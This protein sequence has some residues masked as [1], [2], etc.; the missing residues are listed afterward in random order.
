MTR[1]KRARGVRAL[2]AALMSAGLIVITGVAAVGPTAQAAASGAESAGRMVLDAADTSASTPCVVSINAPTCQS[3]N[4]RL[5]VDVVNNGDTSA[6]TFTYSIDWGDGSA[7]QQV[8]FDG[9]PQ[10]GEY[11]LAAHTYHATQ[12]HSYSITASPVSVTGNCTSGSGSYTFTLD[13]GG[14]APAAPSNLTVKAIDPHDIKLNW[15]DN[16]NN[17]T[18]FEINNGVVS[19]DVAANSTSYTWGGLAPGTYMCFR[20]RAHNSA[21]N[22]AWD[23][24]VS[25]WYACT[26]TPKPK[27]PVN[28]TWSG[29]GGSASVT[30]VGATHW[31]VP[32]LS[33]FGQGFTQPHPAAAQWIGLGGTGGNKDLE[34]VGILSQCVAGVQV[35]TLVWEI[36]PQ[37][38]QPV[39]LFQ[40]P[41]L[42]GD[43]I[44][45]VVKQNDGNQYYF[46]V[47]D[48]NRLT[49]WT[50]QDYEIQQDS[51]AVPDSVEWVM[52]AQPGHTARFNPITFSGCYYFDASGR[53][54]KLDVSK[55][56]RFEAQGPHGPY[57]SVSGRGDTFTVK[58]VRSS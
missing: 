12:T 17:E 44:S 58:F 4:P 43:K 2:L 5:T 36:L 28:A 49:G 18:G 31:N 22:S 40:Y 11:F 24:N 10:S 48:A 26:T 42:A 27:P 8:T 34:Q 56:G 20:I 15:H 3:T 25:P 33:C 39:A 7:A 6:C 30:A 35:N 47:H 29:Y 21:G 37:H 13:V 53:R 23:P 57:T 45:A 46:W 16:S 50:W 14:T 55:F 41:V 51:A 52:E 19:K 1:R 54:H 38:A 32:S 9:K